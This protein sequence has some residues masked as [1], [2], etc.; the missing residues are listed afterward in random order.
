MATE[1]CTQWNII[2]LSQKKKKKERNSVICNNMDEPGGRY[3]KWCEPD[4][5]RQIPHGITNMR[6]LKKK[7]EIIE[8]E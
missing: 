2:H 6:N 4:R 7:V 3:A 1:S 5:E 8:T